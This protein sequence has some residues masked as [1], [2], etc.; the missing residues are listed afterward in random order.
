MDVLNVSPKQLY[1][2]FITK[3]GHTSTA[4]GRWRDS[5]ELDLRIVDTDE[6]R[7]VSTN[8][9][10]ATRETKLQA[11]HFKIINRII[12]CGTYLQQIRIL[13]ND[14]CALCGL[15]DS[16]SHFFYDCTQCKSFWQ[17][18][19]GWFE[20]VEDLWL[21]EINRKHFLLGLPQSD[22]K[23]A[24]INAILILVKFYIHRQRLMELIHWLREF[25]NRLLLEREICRRED[26]LRR[27]NT[28]NR[29]LGA[30]G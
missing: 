14:S 8:V 22:P 19:C 5:C 27:F 24:K 11:L 2:A 7:D 1:R 17:A 9:Y 20:G 13:Q 3:M 21:A 4:Y 18:V 25:R 30:M 26:R 23:A 28:W 6:W 10:R 12:P 29:I 16:L 15:Q